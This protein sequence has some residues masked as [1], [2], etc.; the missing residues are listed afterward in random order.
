MGVRICWIGWLEGKR[1]I[2]GDKEKGMGILS[3]ISMFPVLR[4]DI[5]FTIE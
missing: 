4:R 1:V 3:V 5:M 2:G